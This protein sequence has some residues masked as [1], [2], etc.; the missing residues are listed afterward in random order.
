MRGEHG[1]TVTKALLLVGGF[2]AKP[3]AEG[4]VPMVHMTR[5]LQYSSYGY[6]S[7]CPDEVGICTT[8]TSCLACYDAYVY[9]IDGCLASLTSTSTCDDLVDALCCA[10]DGCHDNEEFADAMGTCTKVASRAAI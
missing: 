4:S 10:A 5:H 9:A 8:S 1:G 2:V 7:A 6:S 3:G